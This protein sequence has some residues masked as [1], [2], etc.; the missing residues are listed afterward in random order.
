M[1]VERKFPGRPGVN[2]LDTDVVVRGL[3]ITVKAMSFVAC[4]QEYDL[5]EDFEFIVEPES[6]VVLHVIAYLAQER[7]SGD[8]VVVVSE[9]REHENP[10]SFDDSSP[11]KLLH[12]V[13]AVDVPPNV[14]TLDEVPVRVKKTV[15]EEEIQDV[16]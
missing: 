7:E 16:N 3:K 12:E 14:Y 10:Y 1:I 6:D 2:V 13:Y 11:Y 4:K 9:T 8:V 5:S 15:T